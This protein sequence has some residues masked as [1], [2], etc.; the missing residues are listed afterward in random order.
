M[1]WRDSF[2]FLLTK[3]R[4]WLGGLIK[5]G[6]FKWSK[7]GFLPNFIWKITKNFTKSTAIKRKKSNVPPNLRKKFK[8]PTKFHEIFPIR[9]NGMK[10]DSEKLLQKSSSN[11]SLNYLLERTGH[12]SKKQPNSIFF[13]VEFFF[14]LVFLQYIWNAKKNLR[15]ISF[16]NIKVHYKMQDDEEFSLYTYF[17]HFFLLKTDL[18]RFF[19]VWITING[20]VEK[21]KNNKEPPNQMYKKQQQQWCIKCN[22]WKIFFREVLQGG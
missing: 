17:A 16:N 21:G 11:I 2:E 9:Q 13:L 6:L 12:H 22:L 20:K 7:I 14:S 5:L 1:W 4:S 18:L 3:T 8:H 15:T 10:I 19:S